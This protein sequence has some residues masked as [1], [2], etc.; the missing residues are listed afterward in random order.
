MGSAGWGED[1]RNS[2]EEVEGTPFPPTQHLPHRPT[3]G[4]KGG[5]WQPRCLGSLGWRGVG[6]GRGGMPGSSG[7]E[8]QDKRPQRDGKS[9]AAGCGGWGGRSVNHTSPSA[10]GGK[11]NGRGHLGEDPPLRPTPN[12]GSGQ[13]DAGAAALSTGPGLGPR[14]P[15]LCP[16]MHRVWRADTWVL[17]G[18]A[19]GGSRGF[20]SLDT[21]VP[22]RW[23]QEVVGALLPL[24]STQS[25]LRSP[26]PGYSRALRVLG[27]PQEA[28]FVGPAI[29]QAVDL[30]VGAQRAGVV[31]EPVARERLQ[32][33]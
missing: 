13:G 16:P 30:R 32:G 4:S 19:W 11:G 6:V 17:W 8:V 26:H 29:G 21:W 10:G 3:A 27:A 9:H 24:P 22:C 18:G 20:R 31:G 12:Q 15:N 1:F 7:K 28:V 14:C 2:G 23:E 25:G 33:P 5:G